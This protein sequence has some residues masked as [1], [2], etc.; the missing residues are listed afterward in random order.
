MLINNFYREYY[1]AHGKSID[2]TRKDASRNN[3]EHATLSPL[4]RDR[5]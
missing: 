2:F 3:L 4:D 1:A 5:K